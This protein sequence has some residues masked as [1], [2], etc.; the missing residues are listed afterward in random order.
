[1]ADKL[2][3]NLDHSNLGHGVL[4]GSGRPDP[5]DLEIFQWA[6]LIARDDPQMD[7]YLTRLHDSDL[8]TIV[9][10]DQ[11]AVGTDPDGW[12]ARVEHLAT[13]LHPRVW[14]VGNEP[15][16][17]DDESS[18][19]SQERYGRLVAAAVPVLREMQPGARVISAGLSSGRASWLE[20][21]D[22]AAIARLDGLAVHPYVK[23]PS[24][25]W[26]AAPYCGTR[27]VAAL[28]DEYTTFR[29]PLWITEFGTDAPAAPPHYVTEMYRAIA[30]RA[31]VAA[32]IVYCY[33]QVMKPGFGLVDG[34]GQIRPAYAR[35]RRAVDPGPYEL[36]AWAPIF[37][38]AQFLQS[39]TGDYEGRAW[40]PVFRASHF[41]QDTD[42]ARDARAADALLTILA[43]N[44][45]FHGAQSGDASN[46]LDDASAARRLL[47]CLTVSKQGHGV[48]VTG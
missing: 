26:P 11:D 19:L 6:R 28:L 48:L 12:A 30:A 41:L 23:K 2:G 25:E 35:L 27:P 5:G 29:K 32:A 18:I 43:G 3:V 31:D 16:G 36:H 14:Q 33:S 37:G 17:E 38:A 10:L 7:A 46:R 24:D 39:P 22:A 40:E 47:E 1:V 9:V 15:D 44:K 42:D 8:D 34:A 4:A 45:V 13:L 21:V 20:G